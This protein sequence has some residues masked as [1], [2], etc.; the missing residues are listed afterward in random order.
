MGVLKYSSVRYGGSGVDIA[1]T[2]DIRKPQ[3]MLEELQRQ[4]EEEMTAEAEIIPTE[5]RYS[6][7]ELLA[8]RESELILREREVEE[9][10]N[11][12]AALKAMYIEQGKEVILEAKRRGEGLV[13]NAEKQAADIVSDAERNR[14]DVFIKARAEGYEQGK[15]DGVAACL[16]AG[17]SILDEARDF[18]ERINAQKEEL[19]ERYE[20]EIYETVMEIANKVTLGSMAVKDG[21]AAKKLIKKAAKEFRNAQLIR[22]TLDENGASAEL[23]GDYE[24]LKELCPNAEH[25]EV[26]L[27]KDAEAGTVIVD[28]GEEITDAGILTQLKMIKE[29][30]DGK[31]RTSTP[32][33]RKKAAEPETDEQTEDGGEE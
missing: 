17:Q 20:K 4:S 16:K 24:Y 19:F 25:V 22:I 11:E 12:L 21:T 27:L 2:V 10:E 3:T 15:K 14:D 7:E 8:K 23:A 29:L 18:S 31:F 1:N 30:G 6:A 13:Q 32:R 28:N 9:R 5:P 26:E 33:K